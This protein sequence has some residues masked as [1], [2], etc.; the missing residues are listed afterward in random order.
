M[1]PRQRQAEADIQPLA[2]NP[3][4]DDSG[5]KRL[6]EVRETLADLQDMEADLLRVARFY[7]PNHDDGILLSA[8]PL[9][10]LFRAGKWRKLIEEAWVK[11]EAGDYD[12]AHIALS[13]WPARVREKC[14]TDLSMAIAHGLESICDVKPKEKRAKASPKT[15]RKGKGGQLMIE[16]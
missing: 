14:R 13:I 4:I 9:H 8:A 3:G 10:R 5:R 12:W 11:L 2:A 6:T 15:G 1:Q 7:Q 16:E